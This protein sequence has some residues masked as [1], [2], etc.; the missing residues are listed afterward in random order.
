[1]RSIFARHVRRSIAQTVTA[2]SPESPPSEISA[3][4][5]RRTYH[6]LVR[7]SGFP[8]VEIAA[9]QR[10]AGVPMGALKDWLLTE[11]QHGRAT[12]STGDWSL[13]SETV[14]AGVIDM[15]GERYLLVH[16]ES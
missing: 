8:D 12:F 5:I 1:M 9:L 3:D 10:H 2:S 14:R 16:L 15:R 4:T 6:D 11:H 13:A 7:L